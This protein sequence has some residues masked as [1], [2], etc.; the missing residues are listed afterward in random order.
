MVCSER[1]FAPWGRP[2]QVRFRISNGSLGIFVLTKPWQPI[3]TI[4]HEYHD[5]SHPIANYSTQ[6]KKAPLLTLESL[7]WAHFLNSNRRTFENLPSNHV[8]YL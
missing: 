2:P 4:T 6:A 8:L 3:I 5:V 1:K 7:W